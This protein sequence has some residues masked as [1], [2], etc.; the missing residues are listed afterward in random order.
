MTKPLDLGR[1]G[2]RG[3]PLVLAT[4]AEVD[5]LEQRLG[6]RFPAGYREYVTRL[7]EGDLNVFVRVLPP[8]R[9]LPELERHRGGMAAYWSWESV[10]VPFGQQEAMA[11]IPI[12]D[13]FGGDVITFHPA[14]PD[15]IIVLPRDLDRLY[16]RGPDLLEVINWVCSGRVIRSFGPDR[17]FE[18][19]DSRLP[20]GEREETQDVAGSQAVY[21]NQPPHLQG[22]ARDVLMAYFEEL[23]AVEVWAIERSGG[24]EAFDR[25]DGPEMSEHHFDELIGR[26]GEVH[27]RYCSPSLASAL[28]G[29]S[30]TMTSP[31]EHD[32]ASLRILEEKTARDG[33]VT[34]RAAI[35]TDFAEILDYVLEEG[36]GE[37][38]I[39]SRRVRGYLDS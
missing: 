39:T 7:G 29:A 32:P 27:R 21:M 11:S 22:S 10:D 19:Y 8:W 2:I 28:G 33:R 4:D 17:Y 15:R 18:P 3:G 5:D 26:S 38:R 1:V 12:A 13:T 31:P 6:V 14:S 25:D 16:A 23:R 24:H 37:W 20:A 34:I 36:G 30:V 9:V 35:G